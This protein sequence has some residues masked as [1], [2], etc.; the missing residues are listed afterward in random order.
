MKKI[1]FV[2]SLF[3]FQSHAQDVDLIWSEE[4]PTKTKSGVSI[5]GSNGNQYYTTYTDRDD[6]LK[7]R[8]FDQYMKLVKESVISF[9][10]D[11]DTKYSYKGAFFLNNNILH[12]ISQYKKKNKQSYLFAGSTDFQLKTSENVKILNEVEDQKVEKFGMYSISPDSTKILTYYEL[13]TKKKEPSILVFKVFDSKIENVFNEGAVSLPIK[14]KNYSTE[15]IRVD[16]LGNV[17]VMASVTKEKKE[18]KKN[19]SKYYYKLVVFAKDKTV[20]EFDFDFPESNIS[21]ADIIAGKDNTFF[22]T[23]FLTVLSNGKKGMVSDKMFFTK[24]DCKTLELSKT[25]L[26]QVPGLYPDKIKKVQDFVPY[27]IREIYQK[28]DGGFAIVAEQYKLIISTYTSANGMTHTTYRYYYCDIACVQVDNKYDVTSVTRIPKYQLNAENPSIISTFINDDVYI[29][30]E[31]VAKNIDANTDKK[32]K[33]SSTTL[34]SNSSN[35]SLFL[36]R[37]SK[38]GEMEKNIIYDYKD[39]KIKPYIK[40]SREVRPGQILLNAFDQIGL[41]TIKA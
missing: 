33:R 27:K 26:L 39:T 2:L 30:Y 19:E 3:Y 12:F 32:I 36:L 13:K 23:G 4:I 9:N 34:F 18:Q 41:L 20:K 38:T 35:N 11:E 5:L 1:L 14:S 31:D 37:I 8:I 21:Y 22:C 29:V 7:G 10:L 15:E 17:Y 28:K 40:G 25:N 16:N 6:N 24:I